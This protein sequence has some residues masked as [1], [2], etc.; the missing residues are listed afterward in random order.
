MSII[1]WYYLHVNGELIYKPSPDAAED[2]RESDLARHMWAVDV[3]NRAS[4]WDILVEAW[5]LGAKMDRIMELA[6]K[7]GCHDADADNYAA[8]VGV[9][10]SLDGNMWCATGPGFVNVQ[11]SPA[12]F[13]DTKL[14]AMAELARELGMYPSKM[15]APTF[16]GL[17]SQLKGEAA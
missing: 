3:H 6:A 5:A 12:G 17:L 4:A 8:R 14:E 11:E 10:I 13:G 9:T 7:W 16:Q 15:W 2:I 1:G